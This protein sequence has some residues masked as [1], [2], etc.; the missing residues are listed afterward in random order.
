MRLSFPFGHEE[1]FLD[2]PDS[3]LR[4]VLR[5]GING[6]E[7]EGDPD[8]LVRKALENPIG[9]KRLCELSAG[10]KKVVIICSD[11]TR[12][13]PSKVII[14][15]MLS[16]IRKGNP[17][18]DI[19]L[20]ISTGCHRPTTRAEL[21]SKFGKEIVDS[22]RIVV[23]DCDNSPMV[24][25]GRL[26][27][28][29]ELIVNELVT[30]ADLV[31]S[32]GFIEPHFFAGF[33]GGRKSVLPG[34]ASRITV[35]ANHCSEFINDPHSRTGI[36]EDN[37]IHKDMVW[38]ARR[39]GLAFI[40]NVVINAEKK[41]IYAVS[42]DVEKAHEKG[43]AFLS[44]L[45][46]VKALPADVAISTNGGYPLDQ[47]IYQSVKG[48]TAAEA[49]VRQGGVIIMVASCNDGHGGESFFRQISD[50]S[51][52]EKAMDQILARGRN[53]TIPDQWEAQILLRILMKA[54][55]ILVSQAPDEMIKAMH[56]IP[57]HDIK[58]AMDMA[59]DIIGRT[60]VSVT[61][62]PDGVSVMVV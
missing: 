52:L 24:N 61:A 11:H 8:F 32:E 30:S 40:C 9:S 13:V 25:L 14:P 16:E 42:G 48:M 44:K 34:I 37:N 27:S 56:M 54:R 2:V 17:D 47:N 18:A 4:G 35:M 28:G 41:V 59:R 19:T 7:P 5:S 45:C 3:S 58:S 26:P 1:Q 39:A 49:T 21:E 29:G 53:E 15:H 6:Y 60:D 10:K 55:V 23:H 31:C 50:A 43:C 36:L 38:A 22:E 46:A 12:P 51:S 57:A 33:S 62:I 20:L